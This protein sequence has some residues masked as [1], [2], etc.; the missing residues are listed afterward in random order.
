MTPFIDLKNLCD[1]F[2]NEVKKIYQTWLPL[3]TYVEANMIGV[4]I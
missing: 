4:N 1:N 2:E 3:L